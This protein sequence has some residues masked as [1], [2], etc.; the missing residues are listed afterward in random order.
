[1]LSLAGMLC[2]AWKCAGH[3]VGDQERSVEKSGSKR[4]K[5][6]ASD[7]LTAIRGIGIAGQNRLNVAGIKSFAQ[8]ARA[9][10]EELRKILGRLGRSAKVEDWID[11]ARKLAGTT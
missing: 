6:N 10:P 7:D 8:L 1:M 5:G 4:T 11:Q 2:R 9:N 3:C